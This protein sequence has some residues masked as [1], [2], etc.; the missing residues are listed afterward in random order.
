MINAQPFSRHF[1]CRVSD[2]LSYCNQRAVVLEN[3]VLRVLVLPEK[4]AEIVEMLYKPADVDP[5]L[6]LPASPRPPTTYPATKATQLGAF[7]DAYW[8]GWQEMFPNAGGNCVVKGA[9]LGQHGEVTLLPWRWQIIEDSPGRV[10]VRFW[11][12]T[13]RTPF[14]LERTMT[15]ES[16]KAVLSL[17]GKVINQGNEEMPF[18]WG[19]HI[20]Y[21]QPFLDGPCTLDT[22]ASIVDVHDYP[23]DPTQRLKTGSQGPWPVLP[24]ADG[25]DVDMRQMPKPDAG[26]VDMVYLTGLDAGWYG[27]INHQLQ[28]G[29]AASWPVEVFPV[30]WLWQEFCGSAGYPFYSRVNALGVEPVTGY[31]PT[32][33]AGLAEAIQGNKHSSLAPGS[34]L[35]SS[36]KVAIFPSQGATGVSRVTPDGDVELKT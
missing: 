10:S 2:A 31:A 14:Y 15:L 23:P 30:I 7:M 1:A 29:V 13:V 22:P 18:L 19:H 32:N 21:G 4:G 3:E 35:E 25:K 36:L 11:V 17:A 27:L 6:R 20:A 24:G 12:D 28:I 34:H 33:G 9:E 5:L 16:G 26:T 8:G